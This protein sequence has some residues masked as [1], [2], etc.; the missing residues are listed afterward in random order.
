MEV[1]GRQQYLRKLYSEKAFIFLPK[2]KIA[3]KRDQQKMLLLR[4][5]SY[6]FVL[7]L[8]IQKAPNMVVQNP[9][10]TGTRGCLLCS[11]QRRELGLSHGLLANIQKRALL[12]LCG[13]RGLVS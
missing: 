9:S 10:K 8:D 13:A 7:E 11:W 12:V 6:K 1:P 3:E 5:T 2:T 4:N